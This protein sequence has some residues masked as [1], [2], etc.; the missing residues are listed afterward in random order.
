MS[1][2]MLTFAAV[3]LVPLAVALAAP[4]V[5][6]RGHGYATP[7]GTWMIKVDFD[8]IVDPGKPDE[9]VPFDLA[10]LQDFDADGRTTVLLPFGPGHPNE[11]D[12]RVG[13]MGEWRPRE[14]HRRTYDLTMRCLYN[15]DGEG[16]YGE[17]RGV[18]KMRGPDRLAVKFSYVDHNADGSIFYFQ[19]W[20]VM[21]GT[22]IKVDPLP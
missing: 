22:R 19:G 16:P 6:A 18:M 3:L 13:C 1:R 12:T 10:Y 8:F 4:D 5:G 2:K 9:T 17:I 21:K 14:G 11:E 15:Q 20:G 7:S